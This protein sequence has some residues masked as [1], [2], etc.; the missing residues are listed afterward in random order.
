M[1]KAAPD[2]D[3]D[4]LDREIDVSSGK[5]QRSP[6]ARELYRFRN[7]MFIAPDV[8]EHFPDSETV[9]AALRELLALRAKTAKRSAKTVTVRRAPKKP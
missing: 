5:W 7:F 6:F 1:K 9:N 2:P 4:P 8:L 3:D